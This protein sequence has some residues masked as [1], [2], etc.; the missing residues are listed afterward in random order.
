[1][2]LS[3]VARVAGNTPEPLFLINRSGKRPSAEGAA[4]RFDQARTLCRDA[5]FRRITFRGDTDFSQTRHLDRW[6]ADGVRFVFG[7]D[8]RA[9]VIGAADALPA[10]AWTPLVRR[11]RYDVQTEPRQRPVNVQAGIIVARAFKSFR[12]EAEAVAECPSTSS[13]EPQT[14]LCWR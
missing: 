3:P 7:C 5:G 11:P 10:Q 14:R 9:N 12:L 4:E 2:G 1:M 13:A 8:A 6:D